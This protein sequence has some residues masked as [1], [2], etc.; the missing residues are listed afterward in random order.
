MLSVVPLIDLSVYVMESADN[1]EFLR[2]ILKVSTV[3]SHPFPLVSH[4]HA[5]WRSTS[6]IMNTL[7]EL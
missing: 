6:T 1:V 5:Q 2:C 7:H 4:V 3:A